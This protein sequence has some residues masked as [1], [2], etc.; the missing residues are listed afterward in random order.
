MILQIDKVLKKGIGTNGEAH[1]R[2][3]IIEGVKRTCYSEGFVQVHFRDGTCDAYSIGG[4][5]K[6]DNVAEEWNDY[7]TTGLW[8]LNDEGK[9]LRKLL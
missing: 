3:D 9:T 4:K 5:E 8:L 2:S 7:K 1:L 6:I